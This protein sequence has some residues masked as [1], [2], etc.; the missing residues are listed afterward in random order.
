MIS[1]TRARE[2]AAQWQTPRRGDTF[3]A[4]ASTGAILARLLDDIDTLIRQN[5][6][7]RAQPWHQEL[8]ALRERVANQR[9]TVWSVGYNLPGCLPDNPASN[10]STAEYADA[11][12]AFRSEILASECLCECTHDAPVRYGRTVVTGE[13]GM[14]YCDCHACRDQR[15]VESILN[16]PAMPRGNEPV[17]QQLEYTVAREY[18]CE[19]SVYPAEVYWLRRVIGRAGDLFGS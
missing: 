13:D 3:S 15:A 6:E 1:L 10:F 8:I 14:L 11:V 19:D 12:E 4:F 17:S 16:D 7:E 18:T 2:I 5:T 9:V